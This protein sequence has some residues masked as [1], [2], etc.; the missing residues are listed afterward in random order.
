MP[1][2]DEIRGHRAFPRVVRAARVNSRIFWGGLP[3]F[4]IAAVYGF[5][6]D[7]VWAMA[8]AGLLAAGGVVGQMYGFRRADQPLSEISLDKPVRER[9]WKLATTD[10]K[11]RLVRWLPR[12]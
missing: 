5:R 10:A 7:R 2:D 4:A 3:L 11:P 8:L 12:V 1:T 6:E 9:A